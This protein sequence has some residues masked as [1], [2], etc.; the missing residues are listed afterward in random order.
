MYNTSHGLL[1]KR[2]REIVPIKQSLLKDV[3]KRYGNKEICKVTV[4]QAIGGM[5]NV[6]GLFYD[7]SLLDSKTVLLYSL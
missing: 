3:R 2:M 7:A 4:D 5:R 1:K 6:F